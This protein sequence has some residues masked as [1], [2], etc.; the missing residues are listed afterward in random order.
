[1]VPFSIVIVTKDSETIIARL[2]QSL[3][4]LSDDVIVCDTGSSDTTIA[5]A[6]QEGAIVHE[7]PWE[8]Y[9]KSKNVATGFAKHDWVLSLDSDEKIDPVLYQE[10]KNWKPE[11][12]QT[13]HQVLWKNFFGTQ[14]IRHSDWGNSWKNRLFNRRTV[15]WDHAIA[16]EDLQSEKP[17]QYRRFSGYL[18]HYSFKDMRQYTSKMVHS[19]LITAE[20]YHANGKK[21]ALLKIVFAPVVSFFKTYLIKRG[22]LDGYKGWVIAVVTAHYTFV[23]YTRLYELNKGH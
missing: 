21:V 18:E 10:L 20:K 8:G 7:I 14:W 19:A 23:K 4:G 12:D 1:M 6:R 3:K 22:F 2:L 9:G 5:V 17:L 11:S 15:N 16:H 13:V